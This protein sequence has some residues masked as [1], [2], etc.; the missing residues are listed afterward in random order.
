MTAFFYL[1][2]L[3]HFI[4]KNYSLTQHVAENCFMIWYSVKYTIMQMLDY[5]TKTL[6][7][8]WEEFTAGSI[9]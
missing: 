6:V 5:L 7:I 8:N 4:S 9:N 2:S 3:F 1:I